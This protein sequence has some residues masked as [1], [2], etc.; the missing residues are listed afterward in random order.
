MRPVYESMPYDLEIYYRSSSHFIPHVHD[1]LEVIYILYGTLEIGMDDQL[2]HMEKGDIAILFPGKIHHAQCF[3]DPAT[4]ASMYLLAAP[5]LAGD[6]AQRITA[7]QPVTPVIPAQQVHEDVVY[8]LRRLYNDYGVE[9]KGVRSSEL[10]FPMPS[11]DR[12]PADEEEETRRIVQ[13]SLVQ[14]LL[15]RALPRM[16]L[17][18]RPDETQSGLEYQIVSYAAA[19]FREPLTLSG[20][21]GDLY[22][23]PYRLSRM[24]SAVFHTNFNGFINDMR[25]D[26]VT[27]ML[28]Y[29]EES[30]TEIYMDAGFE[31]QRTFNRVF[32]EKYH[33][34]PRD[35]RRQ[36]QQTGGE[37][38]GTDI[39]IL[40]E[41]EGSPEQNDR[42][43]D[44]ARDQPAGDDCE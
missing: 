40:G 37:N 26:Y 2:F 32:R 31:S 15:A 20:M 30:I 11:G 12:A 1:L 34:S 27:S 21:A 25:L 10:I 13:Q 36:M 8:S 41:S 9:S 39:N 19:H 5:Q 28:Q 35:Y 16:Q 38:A 22:V 33:M 18:E 6:Y 29:S 24:F 4:S 44:G 42:D 17:I 23:S 7:N 3:D 43:P 14:L